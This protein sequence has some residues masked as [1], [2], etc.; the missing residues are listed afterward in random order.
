M[1]WPA[2]IAAIG[3]IASSAVSAYGNSASGS[4]DLKKLSKRQLAGQPVD[5]ITAY[6]RNALL[7]SALVE[8]LLNIQRRRALSKALFDIAGMRS[9][10]PTDIPVIEGFNVITRR[11]KGPATRIVTPGGVVNT[12]DIPE[13]RKFIESGGSPEVANFIAPVL[14]ALRNPVVSVAAKSKGGTPRDQAISSALQNRDITVYQARDPEFLARNIGIPIRIRRKG[15]DTI[16]MLPPL[17]DRTKELFPSGKVPYEIKAPRDQELI[18]AIANKD[19][20]AAI[21]RLIQLGLI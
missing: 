20:D 4:D 16:L 1:I 6:Q 13:V 14:H 7:E 8:E 15:R 12:S 18:T 5:D 21:N 11:E 2:I 9:P 17:G 10:F 3:S 19:F